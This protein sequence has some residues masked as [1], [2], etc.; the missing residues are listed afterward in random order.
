MAFQSASSPL[1]TRPRSA[2]PFDRQTHKGMLQS[3]E[4]VPITRHLLPIVNERWCSAVDT[5]FFFLTKSVDIFFMSCS[6][7]LFGTTWVQGIL[8]QTSV[9]IETARVASS[10]SPPVKPQYMTHA[11]HQD[12]CGRCVGS[13]SR[14]P[15]RSNIPAK[16][17][18]DISLQLIPKQ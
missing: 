1:S 18:T 10:H 15:P 13:C 12:R 7:P 4:W 17:I 14:E 5:Q 9:A 2:I 16:M 11:V 6:A 8:V 3:D